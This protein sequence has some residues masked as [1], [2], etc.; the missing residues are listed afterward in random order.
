MGLGHLLPDEAL[1]GALHTLYDWAGEG[2]YLLYTDISGETWKTEPILIEA[3]KMGTQ[4]GLKPYYYRTKEELLRLLSP[5]KLTE[6]G[7]AD[8]A[9]WGL[10][11]DEITPG[12]LL[13]YGM[14]LYK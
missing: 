4:S 11:E 1:A 14:V 6:H 2:S 13:G 10:A 12:L 9:Q 7:V 3:S 8:N 5:W